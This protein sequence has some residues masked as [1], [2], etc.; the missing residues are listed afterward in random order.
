MDAPVEDARAT[1]RGLAEGIA[2]TIRDRRCRDREQAA[3]WSEDE[4]DL[5]LRD[6]VLI[7]GDHLG[8]AARVIHVLHGH[9]VAEQAALGVLVLRPEVVALDEGLA[10][11]REIP[12]QR[13]RDADRY[14]RCLGRAAGGRTAAAASRKTQH[15]Q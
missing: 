5:V 12:G 14:R 3:E 7:V 13:D 1:T 10:I 15:A 6:Q 2:E 4:C 9:V 11:P 8:G